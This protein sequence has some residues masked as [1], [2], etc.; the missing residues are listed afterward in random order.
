MKKYRVTLEVTLEEDS[1]LK[2]ARAVE[3]YVQRTLAAGDFNNCN[4]ARVFVAGAVEGWEAAAAHK[5]AVRTCADC[6]QPI[7]EGEQLCDCN[8]SGDLGGGQ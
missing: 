3:S 2:N 5:P 7:P 4:F 1:N 8:T 6:G